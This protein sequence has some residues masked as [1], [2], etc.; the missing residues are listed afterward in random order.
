MH[1]CTISASSSYYSQSFY[2]MLMSQQRLSNVPNATTMTLTADHKSVVAKLKVLILSQNG[3]KIIF[4]LLG[5][6]LI[7]GLSLRRYLC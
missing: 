6:L 5:I 2:A 4:C 7:E 3:L 1:I